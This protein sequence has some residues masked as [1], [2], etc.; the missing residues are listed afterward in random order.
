[1]ATKEQIARAQAK[2]DHILGQLEALR[3]KEKGVVL[4]GPSL[5]LEQAT[6]LQI[7]RIQFLNWCKKSPVTALTARLGQL[8]SR[9]VIAT[10]SEFAEQVEY[11]LLAYV[12][13]VM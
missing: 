8:T 11:E 5:S 4:N 6:A 12:L 9:E 10:E 2:Q 13:G 3:N 7:K 1:M